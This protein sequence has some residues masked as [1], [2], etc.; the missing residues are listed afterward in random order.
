MFVAVGII[1]SA[2]V[3]S[4]SVTTGLAVV[5]VQTQF[6]AFDTAVGM[7][8]GANAGTTV[9]TWIA[10]RPLNVNARRAAW[11]H[12]MFNLLGVIAFLPILI[13]FVDALRDLPGTSAA[14]LANGHAIFNI[15][16]VFIA[17]VFLKPFTALVQ[18]IVPDG[19]P[20]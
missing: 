11:A 13:P 20:R 3:Q 15:V 17:L 19:L 5:L 6:I 18:R 16:N 4:S 9:T 1:L 2:V 10:S 14:R 7:V 12:I 8:I